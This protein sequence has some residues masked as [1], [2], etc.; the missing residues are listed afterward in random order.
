[1]VSCDIPGSDLGPGKALGRHLI[2]EFHGCD[3]DAFLHVEKVEDT[4]VKAAGKSGA[5]VVTASFHHFEPQGIS[6]VVVISESHFTL[7]AWPEHDFAAVDIFTCANQ[8]DFQVAV[9]A[10]ALAFGAGKITILADMDRGGFP[11]GQPRGNGRDNRIPPPQP[12]ITRTRSG[13]GIQSVRLD[14][15]DCDPNRLE[16]PGLLEDFG[17]MMEDLPGLYLG[18]PVIFQGEN[19]LGLDLSGPGAT[20]KVT[21]VPSRG[22]VLMDVNLDRELDLR[23]LAESCLLFFRGRDYKLEVKDRG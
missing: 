7:H 20:M 3:P 4:M 15:K 9:D 17:A 22:L 14:F 12:G 19:Q 2:I 13:Q 10:L 23:E 1:M 11:L 16:H 21:L 18:N 8:V 5:T 6:G